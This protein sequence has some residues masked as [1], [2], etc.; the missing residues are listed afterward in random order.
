MTMSVSGGEYDSGK[1][2]L[3]ELLRNWD[4]SFAGLAV[5]DSSAAWPQFDKWLEA[6]QSRGWKRKDVYDLFWDIFNYHHS[7]FSQPT[8]DLLREIEST[9]TGH[10]HPDYKIQFP[11]E[12]EEEASQVP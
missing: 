12:T 5:N 4:S 6:V 3:I 11:G 2:S 1:Q 10:C 7:E 9:L 8:R